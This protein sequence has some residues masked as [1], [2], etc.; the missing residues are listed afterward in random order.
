MIEKKIHIQELKNYGDRHGFIFA[1]V[2][3]SS[4]EAIHR[5]VE[6]LKEKGLSS[7]LPEFFARI[8]DNVVAFVYPEQ[9]SFA[10]GRVYKA[11]KR[12]EGLG[13]FEVEILGY[14][15]ENTLKGIK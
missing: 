15:V 7:T 4:D 2:T 8:D 11:A 3:R 9:C 13:V 12:L 10:S 1:G 6:T 14:F 5:L